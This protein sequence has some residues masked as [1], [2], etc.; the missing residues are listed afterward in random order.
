MIEINLVPGAKRAKRGGGGPSFNF[1]AIGAAISAKVKDKYLAAAVLMSLAAFAAIAVLFLAQQTREAGLRSAETKA[2]EDSTK[3]AAVLDDRMRAQARRDSA[4]LQLNIIK[5]I[6]ED[7]FIWPHVM[8]EVSRAMPIY[9][10][11]QVVNYTGTPQGVNPP[12]AIKAPPP[13]TGKTRARRRIDPVIPRD[14]V[15]VRMVGR[16]VDIQ[17]LTRFMRSLED[18]PFLGRVSLQKSEIAIEGGKEV[19]QFTLDFVF[20]RPDSTLLRRAPITLTQR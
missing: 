19:T 9:T 4:L 20:T 17:A 2:V 10:W 14:T 1:A 6:D 15:Q 12:A 11:L 3:Y 16:T 5:A 18:S 8:E 13:D 7:R